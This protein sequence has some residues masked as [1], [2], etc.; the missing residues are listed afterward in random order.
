MFLLFRIPYIM[1]KILHLNLKGKY[2]DKIKAGIKHEEFRLYNDYWKK[3][4]IRPDGKQVEY[5][6]I[7]LKRG[8]PR[9]NDREKVLERKW[10]GWSLKQIIHPEFGIHPVKVFAIRVN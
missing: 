1:A 10:R 8:Y 4:L 9:K 5:G 6:S 3:R 7:L 2:F